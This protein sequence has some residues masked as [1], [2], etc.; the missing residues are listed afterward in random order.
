MSRVKNVAALMS[1]MGAVLLAGNA[2]AYYESDDWEGT[3]KVTCG[4]SYIK[5]NSIHFKAPASG[6]NPATDVELVHPDYNTVRLEC[7]ENNTDFVVNSDD[8][9]VIEGLLQTSCF[10]VADDMKAFLNSLPAVQWHISDEDLGEW[11]ANNFVPHWSNIIQQQITSAAD[12]GLGV[13][14]VAQYTLDLQDE[15]N[16]GPFG[17]WSLPGTSSTSYYCDA[18]QVSCSGANSADIQ[19]RHFDMW[20]RTS[21]KYVAVPLALGICIGNVNE[22]DQRDYRLYSNGQVV[23]AGQN[24]NPN[25][26]NYNKVWGTFTR[27]YS[28]ACAANGTSFGVS[29]EFKHKY[30]G[31]T[32]E[33]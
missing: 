26:D 20:T 23:P 29:F 3:Y 14:P 27:S 5:L 31:T 32:E 1:A 21:P 28:G 10:N 22:Y 13:Y 16:W 30:T 15:I 19:T 9:A 33:E 18:S 24:P 7:T 12:Q 2:Q 25:G 11:C 8:L 4:E 6:D 17:I